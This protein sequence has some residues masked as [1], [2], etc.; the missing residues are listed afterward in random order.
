[1]M[2]PGVSGLLP[3]DTDSTDEEE[4]MVP[5]MGAGAWLWV[6]LLRGYGRWGLRR[7]EGEAIRGGTA[8]APAPP[9]AVWVD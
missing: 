7:R 8:P 3:A 6:S 1:M 5:V 9:P 2:L 4:E